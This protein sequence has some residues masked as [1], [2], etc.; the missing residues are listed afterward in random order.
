MV[1]RYLHI[2]IVMRLKSYCSI[3]KCEILS[4]SASKFLF[5]SSHSNFLVI[6]FSVSYT[7]EILKT[8]PEGPFNIYF[9][10]LLLYVCVEI[11]F[12]ACILKSHMWFFSLGLQASG[13]N[14]LWSSR[15]SWKRIRSSVLWSHIRVSFG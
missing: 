10:H 6:I 4:L 3:S 11:F 8:W 1:L 5:C 13:L 7:Q 12:I 15:S 9:D 2:I 14:W